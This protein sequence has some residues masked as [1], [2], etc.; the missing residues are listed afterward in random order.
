MYDKL[1]YFKLFIVY[2]I[3]S[4]LEFISTLEIFL[5]E[6]YKYLLNYSGNILL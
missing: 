3:Y 6:V 1:I 4:K 2:L 5:M